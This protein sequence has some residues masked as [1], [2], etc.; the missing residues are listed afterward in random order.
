VGD[1]ESTVGGALEGTEKT[2]AGHGAA[3]TN[4]KECLEGGSTLLVSFDGIVRSIGLCDTL[5]F[6]AVLGVDAAGDQEAGGVG[7]GVV[8]EAELDAVT[9]E[10]VGVCVG[11][12]N[13]VG[14]VGGD[15]LAD[16]VAV[17]DAHNKSVLGGLV[18]VLVLLDESL[19]CVVV[20]LTL[21]SSSKL[22]L[23]ALEISFVLNYFNVCHVETFLKLI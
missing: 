19:T 5:V 11:D 3:K 7:G 4:I 17:G 18:F 21:A 2:A 14:E 9:L 10:L 6:K 23:V 8:G 16:D 1:V 12:D 20:G 13:I 15:N 22:D